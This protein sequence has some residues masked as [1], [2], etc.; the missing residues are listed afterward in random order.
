MSSSHRVVSPERRLSHRDVVAIA[1]PITLSN[2]TTPLVGFVDTLAIGQLGAA[3]LIGGVAIAANIFNA[4]YWGFGFLRMGTTGLTSQAVG[5]ADRTEV[6]ANLF[7]ALLIAGIAGALV[8]LLQGPLARGALWFMGASSNV[9]AAARAYY[10]VRIWAAPA[11]LANFALLGWFIGLGRAGIAF[12]LQL[13][14]NLLNVGLAYLFVI[15]YGLGVEGAGLAALIAEVTAAAV[16]IAVAWRE[17]AARG[18]GAG[19]TAVLDATRLNRMV[20]VNVDITIRTFCVL[21][22]FL[23]FTAQS[24]QTNDLTL[25]ANAVLTSMATIAVYLLDGFAFAAETLIGQ[26]I[27]AGSRARFREAM[28]LSTIWAGVFGVVLSV[29]LWLGGPAIIDVMTTSVEVRETA[30]QYLVWA[31]LTPIVGVW[32]FQLDGVFI[33]AT[34]TADMRNMMILSFLVYV[35]AW[36]VLKPLFAN[37]GLWA[38]LHVFYVVRAASLLARLP[39]LQRA[40]FP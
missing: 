40:T 5:A 39:A 23:F 14:L 12:W 15:H 28:W 18:A 11:G 29:G 1:L 21:G 24:A 13:W 33:G 2:A 8:I 38:A 19:W 10:D 37:H 3:H 20:A 9:E 31:A 16:G 30:L 22:A 25:A 6:A 27:G 35:G 34:R 17:L 7:R 26:S 32:C 4:I 36:A